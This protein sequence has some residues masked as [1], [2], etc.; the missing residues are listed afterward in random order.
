MQ[1]IAPGHNFFLG[2]LLL[3]KKYAEK[4]PK[5]AHYQ[6]LF[7]HIYRDHF[8][9]DGAFFID[10][11]PMS[12]LCFAVFSPHVANLI[13]QSPE[14][15]KQRPYLLPRF[16]KPIAG[17]SNLFDMQEKDW[18]PWRAVFNKGFSAEHFLS[19]VPSMVKETIV[20]AQTF[21][22][23]AQKGEMF[24]LDSTSLRYVM[25]VIGRTILNAELGSQ[26]GHNTLADCMISQIRW[27]QPSAEINPFGSLNI[28]R[29]YMEWWNGKEMDKYIG[30]EL[31]RRYAEFK[32]DSSNTRTKAVMDIILQAY[33]GDG[34]SRPEKLDPDFRAFA[35]RQIRL[36]VFVG[37]DST[38]STICY[39][40]HLLSQNPT[41][42]EKLRTEHD[43]VFGKD[44]EALPNILLSQ[45]HLANELPYTTAVIKETLR[46]FPPA[47]S[48]RQ[49]K[50]NVT[51]PSDS[52]SVCPMDD[53]FI[54]I[55]HEAMQRSP[56]Y[57]VRAAEFIP[58]RFLVESGHELYPIQGAWRPFEFGPRNC[59][60]QGQVML[61]LKVV[62]AFVAREF[63]FENAYGE[64]DHKTGRR[65]LSEVHG[66]RAYQIEEGSAHPSDHY[67]CR[68][69]QRK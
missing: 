14:L 68:V 63:E 37:H 2:H 47:S 66:D 11:W 40:L 53:C 41:A 60:A 19:L 55:L 9:K 34:T 23:L 57:W 22:D 1:P 45:P 36:F 61:E 32:S 67:P 48:S 42:L 25:D 29:W 35:I 52:G 28:A 18:K 69:R 38:S 65:G 49:G 31:D 4:L 56:V 17:G 43:S 24:S 39:I 7:G 30:R 64:W 59:I 5:D 13:Q 16:F 27:H 58:D 15:S 54:L 26:R 6:Y 21:R 62:L 44:I 10:L 20:Y 12:G 46:L 51:V 50:P 33:I 8:E 3:L